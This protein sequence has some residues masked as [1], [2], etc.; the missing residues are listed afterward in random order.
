MYR[1]DSDVV[2]S[3]EA[4]NNLRR[5]L[6]QGAA[7][8]EQRLR[9]RFINQGLRIGARERGW[10]INV[11]PRDI[12]L[13]QEPSPFNPKT[14]AHLQPIRQLERAFLSDLAVPLGTDCPNQRLYGQLLLSAILY[15]GMLHA[16]WLESWFRGIPKGIRMHGSCLWIEMRRRVSVG[17]PS[18]SGKMEENHTVT[19]GR[20]W[21]ADPMTEALLYRALHIAG[22]G[23]GSPGDLT[24]SN[25]GRVAPKAWGYLRGYLAHLGFGKTPLV[26]SLS[27]L[28][29]GI[30]VRLGLIVSQALVGYASGDLKSVSLPPTA[31][32]R[33]MSGKSV[34]TA[35]GLDSESSA[36]RLS[37]PRKS[38]KMVFGHR[39]DMFVQ[40]TIIRELRE[41]L[42]D[43]PLKGKERRFKTKPG[44]ALKAISRV[45]LNRND[46]MCPVLWLVAAWLEYLLAS[47]ASRQSLG[48]RGKARQPSSVGRYL[49]AIGAV[50]VATEFEQNPADMSPDEL[51]E[52]YEE[53]AE[54][55]KSLDE[56]RYALTVMARFHVF[57][58]EVYGLPFVTFTNLPG[59]GPVEASVDANLITSESFRQ[60]VNVLGFQSDRLPRTRE[61][62][63]LLA[64]LG[65]RCGLREREG[66]FLLISDL[67]GNKTVE[68]LIRQ[69][70]HF[71]PKSSNGTRRL[72]LTLLLEEDELR[73]LLAW[74]AMREKEGASAQDPLFSE[75]AL[76]SNT[77]CYV[78]VIEPIKEALRQVTGDNSLVYH[79]LR[80]SGASWLLIR[81]ML[82][83]GS[84]LWHQFKF[85]QGPEFEPDRLKAL[86]RGIL[87]SEDSSRQALHAVALLI[88]H[89]SPDV[90]LQSYV[91]LLDWLLWLELSGAHNAVSLSEEA[92]IAVT[93][94]S[95]S[96]VWL[97]RKSLD[98]S[99]WTV[100]S[101]L[102]S[103]RRQWATRLSDPLLRF[104]V[105][106]DIT[107]RGIE[108]LQIKESR[109]GGVTP[110]WRVV[111]RIIDTCQRYPHRIS[112]QGDTYGFNIDQIKAWL[113]CTAEIA[114][115]KTVYGIQ[116]HI[117]TQ[118][119]IRKELNS[120]SGKEI[121]SR[122]SGASH[123]P[124]PPRNRRDVEL[125][126][127]IFARYQ[128]ADQ[129]NR[130]IIDSG[131]DF[132]LS[133]FTVSKQIIRC[134]LLCQARRYLEFLAILDVPKG[135]I[136]IRIFP[137]NNLAITC[138]PD[139]QQ[140]WATALRLNIEQCR[141]VEKQ[142]RGRGGTGSIGIKVTGSEE[143]SLV[144][145][146]ALKNK[147]TS[148]YGTHDSY[149]FRYA[150]YLI[151]INR[152]GDVVESS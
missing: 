129:A 110:D 16:E 145:K 119:S 54:G 104:A 97:V 11:L 64:I 112:E 144:S 72:P 10:Q 40:D 149:G 43:S 115:M 91:H 28:T 41:A 49:S 142:D 78:D 14:F 70:H 150:L 2:L 131:V 38:T 31:W 30:K 130:S 6:E 147:I 99:I 122:A 85:L 82:L 107:P 66:R 76:S 75:S 23:L 47:S 118:K 4:A 96:Q 74:R 123:F 8:R 52:M 25:M 62:S 151:A 98:D 57:L 39:P 126:D 89:S 71:R 113:S 132:F 108:N 3:A 80:H 81:L 29:V 124:V 44:D 146:K 114:G 133:H 65:F 134:S 139:I 152:A 106:P 24:D 90:T 34:P 48:R 36:V 105:S 103:L 1:G 83:L 143:M 77:A 46:V 92:L 127:R 102:P 69:N 117:G 15:G 138:F 21:C 68:L 33:L 45:V 86:R 27:R 22:S 61:I 60:S 12:T 148:K 88:G 125:V 79:H 121:S 120:E 141:I 58:V 17:V 5:L 63:L 94:C 19:I 116:R 55:K 20:R 128:S 18:E 111:Q 13:K 26:K 95:R 9:A 101:Y 87:G 84:P 7:L 135:F 67:Q 37:T 136:R 42:Y 100:N 53:A 140:K 50:L 109:A 51:A 73:R 56:R 137:P 35:S 93:G 32:T 59:K